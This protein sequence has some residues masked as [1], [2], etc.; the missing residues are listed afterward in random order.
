MI[1]GF[2]LPKILNLEKDN[3]KPA[4]TNAIAGLVISNCNECYNKL[5][6]KHRRD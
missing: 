2:L 5:M 6:F 1:T 3:K 4:I